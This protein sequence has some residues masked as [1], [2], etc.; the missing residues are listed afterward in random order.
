MCGI[1][2]LNFVI[3][4]ET[5]RLN[6]LFPDCDA[7]F[8]LLH[9]YEILKQGEISPKGIKSKGILHGNFRFIN[10]NESRLLNLV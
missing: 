5:T 2:G 3:N 10:T 8:A 7:L 1:S 9:F 6:T 4:V